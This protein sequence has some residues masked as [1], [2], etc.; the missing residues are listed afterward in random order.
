MK[1]TGPDQPFEDPMA[2][3]ERQLFHAFLAG[4][5]QDLRALLAREDEVARRLLSDASKYASSKLAE[6]EARLHYVRELNG[7]A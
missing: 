6:I 5:G 4:A 1:A 7:L 3:L 2:E